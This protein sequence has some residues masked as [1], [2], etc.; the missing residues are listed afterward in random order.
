MLIGALV[1]I[2]SAVSFSLSDVTVRRSVTKAPVAYGAFVT[3]LMG[4]PLFFIV[5]LFTGQIFDAS[6]L[7]ASSYGLLAAAGLV[8]YVIGRYFNYSA[9]QAIG[10]ARAGPI[11]ALGLPYSVIVAAIFL[12]EEIT[13]GM[14]AGI[15]LIMAGPAIMVERRR[16]TPVVA[17]AL[18][19][20]RP[21]LA[22]L[23][24]APITAGPATAVPV[25]EEGFQ[26]RQAEGYLYA[27]IAA[28]SYGSSPVL[29]RSALEGES[30]VS[31]LG[32]FVSYLAAGVLLIVSLALP[33]RRYLVQALSPANARLFFAPGFFVFLAQVFRFVALSLATVAVVATLLR[34][35]GIFTLAMSWY[36][37]RDLEKITWQ[38]IA[39][40]LISLVGAMLLV[41]TSA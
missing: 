20:E 31:L 22:E 39:G 34:F 11:Q 10:A 40:V 21:P 15:V 36:M 28:V 33:S 27:I 4:V 13:L 41:V 12:G 9:L 38:V 7:S 29:I 23:A 8:H 25:K 30:G 19:L 24:S 3:V 2:L 32:G 14:A 18:V 1:A 37:N 26:L 17:A 16:K 5:C 6:E 35:T